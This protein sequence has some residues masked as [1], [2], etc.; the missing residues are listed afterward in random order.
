MPHVVTTDAVAAGRYLVVVGGCNDCHTP[1]YAESGGALPES[2]WLVGSP[3]GWRGPWGTT[4]P[5]N[6][7]LTTQ[8]LSED[9]FVAVLHTRKALPPMLWPAVNALS[10]Q[11]AR[12]I[13]HFIHSLG[14]K[15]EAMPAT[16]PPDAEPATPYFDMMPQHMER[17]AAL[18]PSTTSGT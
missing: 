13:Y 3:V 9:A 18:A 5:A 8:T 1:G 6:L 16:V 7:R 10:E 4:Y 2:E 11:D 17:L 15:G 14:P 12:A